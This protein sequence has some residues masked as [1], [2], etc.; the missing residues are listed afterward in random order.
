[1]KTAQKNLKWLEKNGKGVFW[2][3]ACMFLLV[4]TCYVYLINTATHNGVRWG[5]AEEAITAIGATVSELESRYLS[6]KQSVTL[7]MAYEKGFQDVK[8]VMFISA[9]KVGTLS[10]ALEI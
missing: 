9:R 7:S 10:N 3:F 2:S 5:K 6:L 8:A 1:M 4:A